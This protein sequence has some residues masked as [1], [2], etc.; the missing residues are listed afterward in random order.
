MNI[1]EADKKIVRDSIRRVWVERDLDT[2][3][4]H[5]LAALHDYHAGFMDALAAFTSV[6]IEVV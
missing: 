1:P 2:L 3:P 6:E 4:S 5:G